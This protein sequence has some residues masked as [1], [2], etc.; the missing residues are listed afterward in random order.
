MDRIIVNVF[1]EVETI[2]DK[3]GDITG[4]NFVDKEKKY[5]PDI[6]KELKGRNQ[7]PQS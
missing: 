2:K 4:W 7:P 5:L 1:E 3:E 6:L